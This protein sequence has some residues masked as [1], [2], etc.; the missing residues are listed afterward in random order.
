MIV[1]ALAFIEM[2]QNRPNMIRKTPRIVMRKVNTGRVVLVVSLVWFAATL[3]IFLHLDDRMHA[4]RQRNVHQPH[5]DPNDAYEVFQTL[6]NLTF[7]NPS[8][9]FEVLSKIVSLME[10]G[11]NKTEEILRLVDAEIKKLYKD[12]T[13]VLK[14]KD[15][16]EFEKESLLYKKMQNL[17]KRLKNIVQATTSKMETKDNIHKDHGDQ[18]G[19]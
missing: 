12:N 4:G 10:M 17:H 16:N 13:D 15:S 2:S 9:R 1:A 7:R 19:V 14:R 18:V 11:A 6:S 5:E 8:G 3:L